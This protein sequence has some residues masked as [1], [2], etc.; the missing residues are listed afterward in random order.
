MVINYNYLYSMVWGEC[1]GRVQRAWDRR[2]P[3]ATKPAPSAGKTEWCFRTRGNCGTAQ[4]LRLDTVQCRWAERDSSPELRESHSRILA[5]CRPLAWP[6]SEFWWTV[7][8]CLGW[9]IWQFWGVPPWRRLFLGSREAC[10]SSGS[11]RVRRNPSTG[12]I[13][14]C[15]RGLAAYYPRGSGETSEVAYRGEQVARIVG[16]DILQI[17]VKCELVL[18]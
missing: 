10:T 12:R 17:C 7:E 2:L 6:P 15:R 3:L 4:F 16:P 9:A 1:F 5:T 13:E 11:D 18:N 14:C 8:G